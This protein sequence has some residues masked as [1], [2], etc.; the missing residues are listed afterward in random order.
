MIVSCSSQILQKPVS[1]V[2]R[3]LLTRLESAYSLIELECAEDLGKRSGCFMVIR[4]SI[5]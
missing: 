5:R 2:R 1:S 4:W 3:L